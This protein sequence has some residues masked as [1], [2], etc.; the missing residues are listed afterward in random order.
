[1]RYIYKSDQARWRWT[2]VIITTDATG[3]G[4]DVHDRT[5]LILP[6]DRVDAWLDPARIKPQQ[7]YQVLDGIVLEPLAVLPVS[8]RVS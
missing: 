2:A 4:G 5:P 3:P 6:R 8:I 7:I 1:M